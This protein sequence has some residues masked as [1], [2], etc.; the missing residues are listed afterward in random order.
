MGTS[1]TLL[2]MKH[3]FKLER[4]IKHMNTSQWNYIGFTFT[5]YESGPDQN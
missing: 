3:I 5:Q 4:R 2:V 1:A